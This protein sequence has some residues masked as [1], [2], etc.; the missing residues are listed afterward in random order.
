MAIPGEDSRS[1]ERRLGHSQDRLE[2][3]FCDVAADKEC[4]SQANKTC[5]H[6]KLIPSITVIAK[7]VISVVVM[8]T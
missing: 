1:L 5:V 2:N 7:R 8:S 3:E 6:E 4:C